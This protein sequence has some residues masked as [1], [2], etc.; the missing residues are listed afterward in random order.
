MLPHV[1]PSMTTIMAVRWPS[2]APMSAPVVNVQVLISRC[3]ITRL[4]RW[5]RYSG[6][7]AVVC[8]KD[9]KEPRED[10]RG[11]VR[12]QHT[13]GQLTKLRHEAT[14]TWEELHI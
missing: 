9:G 5:V 3:G 6:H 4:A 12:F 2:L 7:S 10:G 11:W 8:A 1:G 14:L 13:G